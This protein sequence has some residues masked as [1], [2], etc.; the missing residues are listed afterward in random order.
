MSA[1]YPLHSHP[2]HAKCRSAYEA[3]R[4]CYAQQT[5]A[6]TILLSH[7]G[8]INFLSVCHHVGGSFTQRKSGERMAERML[9]SPVHSVG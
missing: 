4:I 8:S 6:R 3:K 1:P 5:Q 9:W 2:R 7:Y